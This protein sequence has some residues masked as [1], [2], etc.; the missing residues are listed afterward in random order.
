[1]RPKILLAAWILFAAAIPA[2]AR[3]IP[4]T[5]VVPLSPTS[6]WKVEIDGAEIR[7]AEIYGGEGVGLLILGCNTKS[8][9]LVAPAD[10]TVRYMPPEN[11]IRDGEGNVSIKG[12]PSDPIC[13]YQV[14]GSQIVFQAEGRKIRV[15]PRAPLVGPQTLDAIVQYSAD[16]ENRIKGYKPDESAVA[17]LSKFGRKTEIRVYFGSWCPHCEAW[18]PRLIKAMQ[19]ASN[20]VLEMRYYAF[21]RN[22][23]MDPE[24]RSWAIQGVP[25][26]IILQEGQEIGRLAGPPESGTIEGALVKILQR[27]GG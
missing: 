1:M 21:P 9:I 3:P 13:S 17:F 12:S 27:A 20:P 10:R 6:T 23:A 5:Q 2:A 26:I 16:Y 19:S 24:A 22:F 8:P 7:A 4:P 11:I 14:S 25:T 18:V 15:S